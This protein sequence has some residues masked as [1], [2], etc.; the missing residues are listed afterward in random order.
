MSYYKSDIRVFLSVSSVTHYM[1]LEV[2]VEI[3]RTETESPPLS[4][5]STVVLPSIEVLKSVRH[6]QKSAKNYNVRQI[7]SSSLAQIFQIVVISINN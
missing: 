5:T 4:H 1:Y 7:L 6:G 3:T 2:H